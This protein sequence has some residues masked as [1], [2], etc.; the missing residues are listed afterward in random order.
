LLTGLLLAAFL[1]PI[2][3]PRC[4]E[5]GKVSLFDEALAMS[6]Y[7]DP[8]TDEKACRAAF[9]EMVGK[10]RR[11]LET[12]GITAANREEKRDEVIGTLNR[13]LLVDRQVSYISNKY[14]RDSLFTAALVRRKGNCLATSLLYH[15]VAQ[16]LKF[17]IGI[18]FLPRHALVCWQNPDEPLYIETTHQGKRLKRRE[19]L[20]RYGLQERDLKPNGFLTP[21]T[22][23]QVRARLHGTWAGMLDSM[24]QFTEARKFLD[25]ARHAWPEN[26]GLLMQH[27]ALL[28]QLGKVEEAR[29][30]YRGL[31]DTDHGPFVKTTAARTWAAFLT[32][33]GKIDEALEVLE[34]HWED[35]ALFHKV[36]M[37]DQLGELYRHKRDW[38][39]AIK[40]HRLHVQ[41]DP[42]ESSYNGLGSV[43]TEAHRDPEAIAAYESALKYNPENFFTRVILAGLYERSGNEKK[44]RALFASIDEPR[45]HKVTWYC[46]LVWYYANIK[47]EEK[48]VENMRLALEMERGGHVYQYF[49]R[50]PDLDP[51]RER[52][53]FKA[54]MD[55]HAPKEEA[56]RKPEPTGVAP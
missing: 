46:A 35:A 52:P 7:F 22:P 31:L 17:P 53:A 33:R 10:V 18:Q 24:G 12:A 27:A 51:Y 8:D 13:H 40:F 32:T 16:E 37:I 1:T 25:K 34:A 26:P 43:L 19:I 47:E 41:L 48:L 44:G 21:L 2:F 29:E 20:E 42:D 56:V 9:A 50:E 30:V 5:P 11:D 45:E 15:L 49:V 54:L 23:A 4:E 38:D 36:E 28:Q 55:A 6:R 14:W 39:K 3:A